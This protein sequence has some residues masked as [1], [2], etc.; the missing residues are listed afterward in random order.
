MEPM[1]AG[2]RPKLTQVDQHTWRTDAWVTARFTV[3]LQ[4][5]ATNNNLRLE[6]WIEDGLG[7]ATGCGGQLPSGVMIQLVEFEYMVSHQWTRGPDLCAD[8]E[9]VLNCGIEKLLEEVLSVLGLSRSDVEWE[10]RAP[11]EPEVASFKKMVNERRSRATV[12]H[13]TAPSD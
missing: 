12:Q 4:K 13:G 8:A 6:T 10:H 5:I 9:D 3:P 1:A 11:T 2:E 7:Q